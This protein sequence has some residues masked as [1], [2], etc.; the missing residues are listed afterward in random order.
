[1]DRFVVIQPVGSYLEREGAPLPRVGVV[2]WL[3][4][5]PTLTVVV[6]VTFSF[7][8]A[9]VG[10]SGV[11][12]IAPEQ[13]PL[14]LGV[15]APDA[16]DE[17][18]YPHDLIPRKGAA[19]VILA[20]SAFAEPPSARIHGSLAVGQVSRSFVVH[21]ASASAR[22]PLQA[23]GVRPPRSEAA[24]RVGAARRSARPR[25]DGDRC[26]DEGPRIHDAGFSYFAYNVAPPEQVSGWIAPDAVVELEGL[27][28]DGARRFQLPGLAPVVLVDARGDLAAEVELACDTLWIDT[29]RE[30]AVL[31]WRGHVEV[32]SPRAPE[33]ERILVALEPH[34]APAPAGEVRRKAARG[35][36]SMAAEEEELSHG[37]VT[38][39]EEDRLMIARYEL[40]GSARAP[41]PQMPLGDYARIS[42]ELAEQREPRADTLRRHGLTEDAWVVEE[43]AW[44]EAMAASAS[45]GDATTVVAYGQLYVAAQDA[46]AAPGEER[47]TLEDFAA[48]K[49]AL[50]GADDAAAVLAGW[51]VT[52]PA[53]MRLERRWTAAAKAD[54]RVA[55]ALERAIARLEAEARG[56]VAPAAADGAE[57]P[58]G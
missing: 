3:D 33:V 56:E 29:D 7:A 28:P 24:T 38:E 49:V 6:K 1:M 39:A 5:E 34:A 12:V 36:V 37:P 10:L 21:A 27:S 15:P 8:P 17:A 22:I 51:P 57:L 4:P 54:P 19:D 48:L 47:R 11:A 13:E 45:R 2:R 26:P 16:P 40:W 44:L 20:G 41:D 18:I 42:A 32:S 9:R 25:L 31:V 55:E 43:R 53:W 50:R 46:L 14:S 23:G 52:L 35:R 58:G 30:L